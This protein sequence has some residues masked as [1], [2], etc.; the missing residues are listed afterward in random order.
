MTTNS[1]TLNMERTACG[2]RSGVRH[3]ESAHQLGGATAFSS[4]DAASPAGDVG[5]RAIIVTPVPLSRC[6]AAVTITG[7]VSTT[8]Y[9]W[10]RWTRRAMWRCSL[11]S[12]LPRRRRQSATTGSITINNGATHTRYNQ[13]AEHICRVTILGDPDE[14]KGEAARGRPGPL[15]TSM[16]R[17]LSSGRAE[18]RERVPWAQPGTAA[19]RL[20]VVA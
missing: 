3:G 17:R 13:V 7:S 4:S 14:A 11:G 5:T 19:A 9:R 12:R 18:D 15:Q 6:A 8:Y 16:W 10:C 2:L 20:G 1:A